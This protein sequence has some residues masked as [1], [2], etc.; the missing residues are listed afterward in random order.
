MSFT[1]SQL[2]RMI[3]PSPALEGIGVAG[4]LVQYASRFFS[5]RVL[6]KILQKI[7]LARVQK[8]VAIS[9]TMVRRSQEIIDERK[10]ALL[11]EGNGALDHQAGGGKDIM[12]IC[13]KC[14]V[15]YHCAL[16]SCGSQ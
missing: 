7:P 6:R 16:R 13:C 10:R 12:S 8:V 1:Y 11:S 14:S 2:L 9:D 5:D 3:T 15:I 4:L